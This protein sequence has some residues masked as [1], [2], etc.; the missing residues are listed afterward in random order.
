M[1]DGDPH[2][3]GYADVL[4]RLP[5]VAY[6]VQGLATPRGTDPFGSDGTGEAS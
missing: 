2:A 6:G 3:T 4:Q 5:G 1:I